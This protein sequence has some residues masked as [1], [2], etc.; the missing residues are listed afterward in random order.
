MNPIRFDESSPDSQQCEGNTL[1]AGQGGDAPREPPK[2]RR[3][4]PL[5]IRLDV[6]AIEALRTRAGEAGCGPSALAA[7]YVRRALGRAGASRSR[8]IAEA[9][10]VA[11]GQLGRVGNN[12]NQLAR[13]A[14]VGGVVPPDELRA[15]RVE[16]VAIDAALRALAS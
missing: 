7:D 3:P 2:P 9:I 13:H 16:L 5:S 12:V 10:R 1:T 4:A 11:T 15:V 8:E 6:A 14:H